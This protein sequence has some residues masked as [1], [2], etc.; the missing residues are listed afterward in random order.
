MPAV[1]LNDTSFKGDGILLVFGRELMSHCKNLIADE[2]R[3]QTSLIS[4]QKISTVYW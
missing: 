4:L 2:I 1:K 3:R